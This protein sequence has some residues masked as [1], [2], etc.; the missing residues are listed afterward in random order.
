MITTA[1]T[2]AT[3]LS[4]DPN[5]PTRPRLR[6]QSS[7]PQPGRHVVASPQSYYC[8]YHHR[9]HALCYHRLMS[10]AAPDCH[11]P[12]SA[13]PRERRGSIAN[14]AVAA[15]GAILGL[16]WPWPRSN[17][18]LTAS[19]ARGLQAVAA[20]VSSS[21]FLFNIHFSSLCMIPWFASTIVSARATSYRLCISVTGHFRP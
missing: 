1:G 12:P 2:I 6:R 11:P 14:G 19:C 18:S 10:A 13:A 7:I 20:F 9:Y 15:D 8:R 17:G 21:L 5:R 16:S 3:K 4:T